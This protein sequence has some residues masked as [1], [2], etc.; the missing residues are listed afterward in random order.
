MLDY[1]RFFYFQSEMFVFW[2]ADQQ[3]SDKLY[4]NALASGLPLQMEKTKTQ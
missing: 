3:G 2:L 1:P 4:T